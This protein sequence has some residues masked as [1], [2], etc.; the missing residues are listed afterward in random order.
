MRTDAP[1]VNVILQAR[2][3]Y[4][5]CVAVFDYTDDADAYARDAHVMRTMS[6]RVFVAMFDAHARACNDR[7][8]WMPLDVV[9]SRDNAFDDARAIVF[10]RH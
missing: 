3:A 8:C 6:A 7:D 10:V 1:D 9:Q 4:D 2:D 5:A